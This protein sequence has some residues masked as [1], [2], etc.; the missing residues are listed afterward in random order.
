[1]QD[2]KRVILREKFDGKM[3]IQMEKQ[4]QQQAVLARMAVSSNVG[5]V[6]KA[7]ENAVQRIKDKAIKFKKKL[8]MGG[9]HCLF[10]LRVYNAMR[11]FVFALMVL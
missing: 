1:M 6:E 2:G 5:A 3:A 7:A 4:L 11:C 10:S 8:V 9:T